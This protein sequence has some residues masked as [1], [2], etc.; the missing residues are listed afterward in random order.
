[1]GY[2]IF[3][4]VALILASSVANL[5]PAM[6]Q[7]VGSGTVVVGLTPVETRTEKVAENLKLQENVTSSDVITPI[8]SAPE[9]YSKR[10]GARA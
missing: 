2:K 3:S 4:L 1:M 5:C 8:I 9:L 6:G 10:I 7:V